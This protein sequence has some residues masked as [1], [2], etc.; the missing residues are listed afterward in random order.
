MENTFKLDIL[1]RLRDGGQIVAELKASSESLRRW[2]VA[3]KSKE[4]PLQE[5]PPQHL[6]SIFEFELDKKLIDEYFGDEDMLHQRR[7]FADT[8]KELTE[9]LTSMDIDLASFTYPWKCDYPF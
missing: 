6:Y 3:Y 7:C 4:Y 8:E 9:L 2:I 1:N 5:N